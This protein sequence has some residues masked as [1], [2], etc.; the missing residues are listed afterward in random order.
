MDTAFAL[1]SGSPPA[2]IAVVRASGPGVRH[3]LEALCG[4]LTKPRLATLC[5]ISLGSPESVIDSGLV[6]F[7]PGPRS[8]TGEDVVEF[9]VHGGR[10]I[11]ARLLRVLGDL[12][13][14]RPA[15]QGEFTRRAF[16]NGRLDLTQA[17]GIADL[18]AAE[19]EDQRRLALQ[20]S[21]GSIRIQYESWAELL[22]RAR[23]LLEAEID[24][25]E[26]ENLG[27]VWAEEGRD[28][29]G[30]VLKEMEASLAGYDGTRSIRDGLEILLLGPVNAGKSTLINAFAG[31]D[32]AIVSPEPGTTRD[33]IEVPVDLGGRKVTFID[34]AGLR[35]AR[36]SAEN[37]GI[38]RARSRAPLADLVLWLSDGDVGELPGDLEAPTW[39]VL[40][41]IDLD[42]DPATIRFRKDADFRLSAVTGEGMSDL[43]EAIVEWASH[44][45]SGPGPSV[46]TRERHRVA[47]ADA[48][49][50]VRAALDRHEPDLAAEELRLAGR[51][52]GRLSGRVDPDDVLDI[53]FQEFC[54]GK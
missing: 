11:V 10:A 3:A 52:L 36:G 24:F 33:L 35:E 26:E 48:A 6:V 40:T 41:K 15:E 29:A 45:G 18:V 20:Q 39:S 28:V 54:I 43:L 9:H 27:R 31:R 13:G 42:V 21:Q 1:S 51:A 46:F 34:S 19:T 53:V 25:A 16:N 49:G 7:F 44:G 37:E 4:G 12:P 17:E 2:G 32:I 50:A 5:E 22:L 38:Q 14:F 8:F 47:V 30:A 23:G